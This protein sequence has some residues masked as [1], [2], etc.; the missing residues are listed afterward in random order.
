METNGA[1]KQHEIH[2]LSFFFLAVAV[3]TGVR[4]YYL[5]IVNDIEYFELGIGRIKCSMP[6]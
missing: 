4:A 2:K 6:I 3:D 5:N 1:L